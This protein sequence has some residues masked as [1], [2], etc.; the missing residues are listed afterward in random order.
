[1]PKSRPTNAELVEE[2]QRLRAQVAQLEDR[3]DHIS[4]HGA[5]A[6]AL[7]QSES[8]HRD[9]M[10]VVADVVLISDDAGRR[11]YRVAYSGPWPRSSGGQ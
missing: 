6:K 10:G 1:M 8:L 2:N 3:L 4:E 9:I 11:I 7:Q 5:A